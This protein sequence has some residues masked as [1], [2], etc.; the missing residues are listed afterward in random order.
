[1]VRFILN[2]YRLHLTHRALS[3]MKYRKKGIKN[4]IMLNVAAIIG[5]LP[6]IAQIPWI[7]LESDSLLC[8]RFLNLS[9]DE[10]RFWNI[11]LIN[12]FEW[13]GK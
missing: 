8:Q 11:H 9:V 1:M 13:K 12:D 2:K 10:P 6:K 7:A 5:L 3:K 4:L